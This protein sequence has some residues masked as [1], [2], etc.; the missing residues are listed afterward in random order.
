MYQKFGKKNIVDVNNFDLFL[1][2]KF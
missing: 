1:L 2:I